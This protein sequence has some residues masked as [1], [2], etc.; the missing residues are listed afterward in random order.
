MTTDHIVLSSL[1]LA[2]F[3]DRQLSQYNNSAHYTSHGAYY[4]VY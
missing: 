3:I 2:F 4:S 1:Y